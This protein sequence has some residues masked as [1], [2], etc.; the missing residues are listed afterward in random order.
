[1]DNRL[2]RRAVSVA[3]SGTLLGFSAGVSATEDMNGLDVYSV[4]VEADGWTKEKSPVYGSIYKVYYNESSNWGTVR[5]IRDGK[6]ET[7]FNFDNE[8]DIYVVN[9]EHSIR[10]KVHEPV[11]KDFARMAEKIRTS[12]KVGHGLDEEEVRR[13]TNKVNNL[14][15]TIINPEVLKQSDFIASGPRPEGDGLVQASA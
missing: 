12:D 6:N 7:L 11:L 9:K 4:V 10:Y 13:I 15:N 1:M 14:S 3:I 5:Y 8:G 2:L